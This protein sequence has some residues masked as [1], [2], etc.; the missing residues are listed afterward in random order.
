M[1]RLAKS[2]RAILV[3]GS[4]AA[5]L[6]AGAQG[7]LVK[8]GPLILRA[9]GGF[10]PT[11]LPKR[12]FVPID[13][14]GHAEIER[15]DGGV[16]PALERVVLDF[17]RDGRL[18]T[19]GLPECPPERVANATPEEA[20]RLCR[21]AIVGKGHVGGLIDVP[22]LGIVR[23]SSLLTIFNGP[24]LQGNPTVV[25]HAR[26]TTPATQTFA[27]VVPIERK[28]GAYGYRTTL[29]VPSIAGGRGA[30]THID[31]KIGRRYVSGGVKRSYVS[32][33]CADGI[34]ETHGIFTF[35]DGT[36]IDGSVAKFCRIR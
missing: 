32:A 14:Q 36:T 4:L 24:R 26:L 10:T 23:A 8:I 35:A 3:V 15:K 27:V 22:G 12:E 7:A 1:N 6:A 33:R 13:F 19:R 16:P 29:D 9:D 11:A 17:D 31:V 30:L 2:L 18:S 21:G 20:R 28:L 25:L 34:L 5:L